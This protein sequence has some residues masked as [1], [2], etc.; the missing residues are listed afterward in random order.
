MFA[1]FSSGEVLC[2]LVQLLSDAYFEEHEALENSLTSPKKKIQIIGVLSGTQ[3]ERPC[4]QN[5]EKALNVIWARSPRVKCMP[6]PKQI[7][8][9]DPAPTVSLIREMFEIY[10]MR[11][12]WSRSRDMFSWYSERC[13]HYG[14]ILPP[15]LHK[16][17]NLQL[18]R[19]MF[20]SGAVICM[21]C[22]SC[23]G[24]K[25][26]TPEKWEDEGDDEDED[27]DSEKE[28]EAS[29]INEKKEVK[30]VKRTS[31]GTK[32]IATKRNPTTQT[33]PKRSS[34]TATSQ[35][36]STLRSTM[37]KSEIGS[38]SSK[39]EEKSI[40]T[41]SFQS[42]SHP[43]PLMTLPPK[44]RK[45][46][47]RTQPMAP[48]SSL[49]AVYGFPSTEQERQHNVQ[50]AL[51]SFAS[52]G[53]PVF[54]TPAEWI[55]PNAT[56]AVSSSR[57]MAGSSSS[58]SLSPLSTVYSTP[59]LVS[60]ASDSSVPVPSSQQRGKEV[61]RTEQEQVEDDILMF[62]LDLIW[63]QLLDCV[64]EEKEDIREVTSSSALATP[65]NVSRS[66]LSQPKTPSSQKRGM[67]KS[68]S[69]SAVSPS[70]SSSSSVA[71][72]SQF[73]PQKP[74]ACEKVTF[75][76]LI[77]TVRFA[78]QERVLR[79]E[80]KLEREKRKE[81]RKREEE[82]MA[83]RKE[84]EEKEKEQPANSKETNEMESDAKTEENKTS[85][86]PQLNKVKRPIS[87]SSAMS[88]RRSSILQN[89][90]QNIS[91][92]EK[93]DEY[94]KDTSE[95][96]NSESNHAIQ[97]PQ[98]VENSPSF[99]KTPMKSPNV[100]Q[101][102]GI[103][104]PISSN[105]EEKPTKVEEKKDDQNDLN[106][107]T[108]EKQEQK[109][110]TKDTE[111]RIKPKVHQ[112][113]I[114][115]L[116][117]NPHPINKHNT[118]IAEAKKHATQDS[119]LPS[120]NKEIAEKQDLLPEVSTQNEVNSRKAETPTK[121]TEANHSLT[122]HHSA[123]SSR[124]DD[125]K[126]KVRAIMSL[127]LKY[128][129]GKPIQQHLP[130]KDEKQP[131]K[132]EK[133]E[134]D[135]QIQATDSAAKQSQQQEEEKSS[136][137]NQNSDKERPKSPIKSGA[138][139][140]ESTSLK[141]LQFSTRNKQMSVSKGKFDKILPAKKEAEVKQ[142]FIEAPTKQ[143][144]QKDVNKDEN[145]EQSN[146]GKEVILQIEDVS[147]QQKE[148]EILDE[149][150]QK[151][152]PYA[153]S[154]EQCSEKESIEKISSNHENSAANEKQE[155]NEEGDI[156]IAEASENSSKNEVEKKDDNLN[157]DGISLMIEEVDKMELEA[158]DD[159]NNDNDMSPLSIASLPQPHT[160]GST[161]PPP[162][163]TD[164]TPLS[165]PIST[166]SKQR[167]LTTSRSLS[168]SSSASSLTIHT[169]TASH[170]SN[171]T[172]SLSSSSELQAQSTSSQ[173]LPEERK[174]CAESSAEE[175]IS[176]PSDK[177]TQNT[178]PS[179]DLTTPPPV[180]AILPSESDTA[181]S[182]LYGLIKQMVQNNKAT[183]TNP[184]SEAEASS[185]L[186]SL[187]THSS[188]DQIQ[189]AEGNDQSNISSSEASSSIVDVASVMLS[190][191]RN[192]ELCLS[193]SSQLL[194]SVQT[195]IRVA[196]QRDLRKQKNEKENESPCEENSSNQKDTNSAAEESG[197]K[198]NS[199][200]TVEDEGSSKASS[201]ENSSEHLADCK[202][203][204]HASDASQSTSSFLKQNNETLEGTQEDGKFEY[205]PHILHA[206]LAT[207][208]IHLSFLDKDQKLL[209]IFV[210]P[211]K[212]ISLINVSPKCPRTLSLSI[213]D[214][215]SPKD[216]Y[217][218][219]SV[220]EIRFAECKEA[221]N[222]V[223]SFQLLQQHKNV[224]DFEHQNTQLTKEN[225]EPMHE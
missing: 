107:E 223:Y 201:S 191:P 199:N 200:E 2:E 160:Q 119:P 153:L 47:T 6:T 32:Q 216:N 57:T 179:I 146:E 197:E 50:L 219:P 221:L 106:K 78:D 45:N 58:S 15:Q 97:T 100:R 190:T 69:V 108:I 39:K 159:E 149:R 22:L 43:V 55:A 10:V 80:R 49:T 91:S 122:T 34:K 92:A 186:P 205:I 141:K 145:N 8:I 177:L 37:K 193:S 14:W 53:V 194:S 110:V 79:V 88:I 94:I 4:V 140:R 198:I 209:P 61:H 116:K 225:I 66:T 27:S 82:L 174:T 127:S 210:I 87:S 135:V 38:A 167:H 40:P 148:G 19:D 114:S 41:S 70:L 180:D 59:S 115:P 162:L 123:A 113:S 28:L 147:E 220:I 90:R 124:T 25:E 125:K 143:T 18:R 30:E 161:T 48:P 207:D 206:N 89:K 42:E 31:G 208:T 99:R 203:E 7:Y 62:Q 129:N 63:R 224:D 218:L 187:T 137:E 118:I 138:S 163:P 44:L 104:K 182:S 211:M 126:P 29:L 86:T 74:A 26:W 46:S 24:G 213:S 1:V 176:Q 181:T 166:P 109:E 3:T 217:P 67:Q 165:S 169:E 192:V 164:S 33:T 16:K 222:Y 81:E 170:Q 52:L 142:D 204:E 130:S 60:V 175:N 121:R 76:K 5:I 23:G 202:Q 183:S 212:R 155:G 65:A 131:K 96:P 64:S 21:A 13:A 17:G 101:Q 83:A 117:T 134:N 151:T 133:K 68:A 156:E 185:S 158:S 178:S 35:R 54:V 93:A 71:A 154:N 72:S 85:R 136:Q 188:L 195:A 11:G 56:K 36:S 103:K 84:E 111:Q 139:L 9:G 75:N 157:E 171:N 173:Q 168:P 73:P 184:T 214:A 120:Q 95:M 51:A 77:S 144:N 196:R 152:E 12:V 102:S 105:R 215:A 189:P 172:N 20:S 128:S 112:L 132:D 150:L 98:K